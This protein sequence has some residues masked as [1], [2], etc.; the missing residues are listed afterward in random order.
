VHF[1]STVD[2]VNLLEQEKE[3][4]KPAFGLMRIDLVILHELSY[5]QFSEG[6][7]SRLLHLLSNRYGHTSVM[8]T[9]NL[10]F[11]E[12]S[13]GGRQ[14]D[15]CHSLSPDASLPHHRNRQRDLPLAPQWRYRQ[16]AHRCSR[17]EHAQQTGCAG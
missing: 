10:S 12:W 1:Y 2:L 8:F 13:S 15:N 6:G 4:C 14:D 5:L 7:G 3:A 16:V 11:A 17:A 9:T